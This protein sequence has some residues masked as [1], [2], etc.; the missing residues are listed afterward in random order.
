MVNLLEHSALQLLR[1]LRLRSV[2]SIDNMAHAL[3]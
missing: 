2:G 3:V 1:R